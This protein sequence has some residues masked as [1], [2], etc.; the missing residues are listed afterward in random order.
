MTLPCMALHVQELLDLCSFRIGGIASPMYTPPAASQGNND[1]AGPLYQRAL[2]I[3]ERALD[4]EHPDIA[5]SINDL[6][7]FYWAQVTAVDIIFLQWTNCTLLLTLYVR[8]TCYRIRHL[9]CTFQLRAG[10]ARLSSSDFARCSPPSRPH[11][12]FVCWKFTI[13]TLHLKRPQEKYTEAAPLLERAFK[14]RA[15]KLGESHPDTVSTLNS[16]K[17]VREQGSA[18]FASS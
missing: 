13:A 17:I 16:L 14:I 3:R 4:P 8:G 10:T 2:A 12:S 6:A 5:T 1:K 18:Y 11:R 7:E 15:K 9:P